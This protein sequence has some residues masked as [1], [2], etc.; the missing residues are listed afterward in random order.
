MVTLTSL[1]GIANLFF[2]SNFAVIRKLIARWNIQARLDYRSA[3]TMNIVM[4]LVIV[5]ILPAVAF[6]KV[7]YNKGMRLSILQEQRSIWK[8]YEARRS[9]IEAR[10]STNRDPGN[11]GPFSPEAAAMA[12]EFI[13]C[14]L[15]QTSDI[16]GDFNNIRLQL[17][18]NSQSRKLC[19]GVGNSTGTAP[20]QL[21]TEQMRSSL[22]TG[23]LIRSRLTGLLLQ[24]PF[25]S[26]MVGSEI[27]APSS[28][29]DGSWIGRA[30]GDIYTL[31]IPNGFKG[32][33]LLITTPLRRFESLPS[34]PT[35]GFIVGI[36]LFLFILVTLYFVAR[37][38]V[39][40]IFLLHLEGCS[41]TPVPQNGFMSTSQNL[42]VIISSPLIDKNSAPCNGKLYRVD[43]K[44][45]GS[46][47]ELKK[48]IQSKALPKKIVLDH[49]DHKLSDLKTSFQK[50]ELLEQLL[51]DEKVVVIISNVDPSAYSAPELFRKSEQK[52]GS[53]LE[54]A[55]RWANVAACFAEVYLVESGDKN[56]FEKLVSRR[57]AALLSLWPNQKKRISEL[58][59]LMR[60]ECS[61]RG[62]LQK[63]GAEIIKQT[64][65]ERI[66]VAEILKQVS[67]Q[68]RLYYQRIWATSSEQEKL[69]LIHLA[70]DKFLSLNDPHLDILLRKGLIVIDPDL[71]LMNQTFKDFLLT[72]C[73]Q[74]GLTS[75]EDQAKRNSTWHMLKVPLI[76]GFVGVLLFLFLTQKEFYGSSLTIVT[77][78]ATGI[79]ALFKI[80]SLFHGEGVG[81]IASSAAAG[82]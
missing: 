66:S 43:C 69:T 7:T 36:L 23:Q 63:I 8:G 58:M 56:C 4:V 62:C 41:I 78:L 48:R 22:A 29:A 44:E 26:G 76:T 70:E 2:R 32:Q 65:L 39:R 53:A 67:G 73:S 61:S 72:Q 6:F 28:A 54:Y 31:R 15:R 40:R 14:R 82:Q 3:Y 12:G 27:L 11:V 52:N 17:S 33:S 75:I 10:Y 50:L 37:F 24:I 21:G 46:F 38:A 18:S 74:T 81:K 77:G 71:R 80:L 47:E 59:R 16:Y 9:R 55:D 45:D 19:P 68:A 35:V 57:E 60:A 20:V 5:G 13:D 64:G 25:A 79:P 51:A 49:F 42:F 34:S 1:L 30:S